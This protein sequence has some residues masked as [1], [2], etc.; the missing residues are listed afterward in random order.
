MSMSWGTNESGSI[1]VGQAKAR[2]P[3]RR[4]RTCSWVAATGDSGGQSLF[5]A[6]P[7]LTCS[8]RR[9]QPKLNTTIRI[10]AKPRLGL[11]LGLATA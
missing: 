4:R 3:P 11:Q 8:A 10:E 5:P 7:R 9:N 2:T 6:T 1:T